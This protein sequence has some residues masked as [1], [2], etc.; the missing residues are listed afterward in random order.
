LPT[1]LTT[2]Y[3]SSY[4]DSFSVFSYA[5]ASQSYDAYAF[6]HKAYLIRFLVN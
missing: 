2:I 5:Y 4:G 1:S 6:Y 3:S